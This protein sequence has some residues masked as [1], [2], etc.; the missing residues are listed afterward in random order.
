MMCISSAILLFYSPSNDFE[1][2]GSHGAVLECNGLALSQARWHRTECYESLRQSEGKS[3]GCNCSHLGQLCPEK[4]PYL[5]FLEDG[6]IFFLLFVHDTLFLGHF[7]FHF[8]VG[9][10]CVD[11]SEH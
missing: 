2:K 11:V 5:L 10:T 6:L 8:S 9:L 3:V 1:G 4:V 7:K